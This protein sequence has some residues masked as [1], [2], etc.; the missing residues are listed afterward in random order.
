MDEG[1]ETGRRELK[2]A[3]EDETFAPLWPFPAC[4]HTAE[5]LFGLDGCYGRG[6]APKI[7]LNP[8]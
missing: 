1:G 4:P 5:E 7:A 2:E 3:Q 6:R 8:T